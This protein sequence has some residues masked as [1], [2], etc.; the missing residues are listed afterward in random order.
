VSSTLRWPPDRFYWSVLDAPG[1]QRSGELPAG[2]RPP[3]EEDVPLPGEGVHAVCC[4]LEDGKMLVCG[5]R[6]EELSEVSAEVHALTPESLPPCIDANIDPAKLNLLV[7]EFEPRTIRRAR[8]VRHFAGA[9]AMVLCSILVAVGLERR[10]EVH[11]G[12]ASEARQARATLLAQVGPAARVEDLRAEV[13]ALRRS[14]EAGQRIHP[15]LDAAP[16]L[17]DLLKRWPAEAKAQPQ[18]LS[19]SGT[20]MGMSVLVEGHPSRFLE[21]LGAPEGW[22]LDQPRLTSVDRST[23]LDLRFTRSQGGGQ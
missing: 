19:I 17:V 7:G 20:S 22:I 4:P 1:W 16:G 23:R 11:R 12:L 21:E 14:A 6:R 5:A 18:S 13:A 2:L 8:R 15:P 3:F 10:A 9:L